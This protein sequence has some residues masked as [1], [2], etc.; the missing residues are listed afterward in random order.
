VTPPKPPKPEKQKDFK[1][2]KNT[3][4]KPPKVAKKK[5]VPKVS[6]DPTKGRQSKAPTGAKKPKKT[7]GTAS[8]G[9]KKPDFKAAGPKNNRK[10][11]RAGGVKGAGNG[12]KGGK[13][14]GTSTA[15]Y[16]GVEGVK[17]NKA[18]GVNLS[19]LGLGAG[20]VLNKSGPGAVRVPFKDSAG[21]AGGGA[22]SAK[23]NYGLGGSGE[24]RSVGVAGSGT[25]INNF[26]SGS[27][28]FDSGQ[29]GKGGLGG[30]GQGRGSGRGRAKVNVAAG[31][32]GVQGGLT[33]EEIRGVIVANL[34][35]IRACYE[36]Y[37]QSSPG[38]S[39]S[40]KVKFKI[41]LSGRVTG[42]SVTSSNIS[43][44]NGCITRKIKRWDFP[45]PRGGEPVNVTYPFNFSPS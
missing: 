25:G 11:G 5:V 35:Q 28:G 13:R 12:A 17:N 7:T 1:P 3:P 22:G 27:G 10:L 33:S 38:K 29:G 2:T 36:S 37:L 42:A 31:V 41:G 20:K 39:G 6:V 44:I 15:D 32:P 23:K 19:A 34:N 21:G 30:V 18:S 9:A 45:K 43:Q 40:V 26:G 8:T 4:K 24:S 16:K 14:K